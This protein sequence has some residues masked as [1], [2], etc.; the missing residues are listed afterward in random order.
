MYYLHTPHTRHNMG[1]SHMCRHVCITHALKRHA[2][3]KGE[4]AVQG[5]GEECKG[6]GGGLKCHQTL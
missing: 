6:R 4:R 2:Q 5:K 1:V 3:W